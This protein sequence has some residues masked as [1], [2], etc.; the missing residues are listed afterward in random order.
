M[1]DIMT[2]KNYICKDQ[3][4]NILVSIE[5]MSEEELSQSP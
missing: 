4:G 5:K 3:A 2:E 1:E